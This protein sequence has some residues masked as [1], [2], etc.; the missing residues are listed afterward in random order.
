MSP[1]SLELV[2]SPLGIVIGVV[3]VLV[4]AGLSLLAW[5]RTGFA[6][7]PGILEALR[8]VLVAMVAIT[9]NQPEWLAQYVP[10]ERPTL[11]VLW[12]ASGSMQTQ[13]V[14][15]PARP[16]DTPKTRADAVQPLIHEQRWTS[17]AEKMNV[18]VEP[19]SS[20]T[21][22][23][24]EGTD[25]NAALNSVLDK[26]KNLR[27][28]VLLSDGDWNLGDP[29]VRAATRLR[30]K[31]IPVF[32]VG[33]GSE[34]RLPDVELVS[35]DAPTFGVVG[36]LMRIPF[37]IESALPRDHDAVVTLKSSTGEVI[38]HDVSIP[39]MGRVEDAVL[40]KP[41]QVGEVVLTMNVPPDPDE[42]IKENNERSVPIT[43]R[44]EA[45]K[46]L[47]VESYP[48]W[49]YRYLR[50]ALE[51]DP[52]VE[53]SCLLF[54]PGLSKVGGGKGYLKEFPGTLEELSKFDVI[55]LGDV[56]VAPGQLTSEH[57]RLIKGLVQ[58]QASGLILMPGIRGGH[59]SLLSTELNELYPV[60]L[61][62]SQPRGWGSRVPA[63]FELTESGRR[64]L[65]T[66][67]EDSEEENARTWETLPGFQWYAPVIR[68]K[69][70]TEVLATHRT[71]TSRF[72][73]VPLLATK[74][75]GTG[76]ILFMGSDGAWRWREGV[77]DKYHYRFWGQVARWMAYQRNMAQGQTMR[78]FYSPDRPQAADVVTLNANV[79]SPGG[80]PLQDGT[81][82]VQITAPSGKTESVQL[83]AGDDEWGLFSGKFTPDEHGEYKLTLS[84]RENGGTLETK[85]SVQGVKRERIGRPA[86]LDVL[87][88]IASVTRG[89]LADPGEM[90][91]ILEQIAALPEPEP[92]VRRLR[93]WCHPVWAG[94]LV[95]LLGVFWVGRKMIG[96]V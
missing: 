49:E 20:A 62:E 26:H 83:A 51:R 63:Q 50:N 70:G 54:H 60:V 76:K 66:K 30:M 91:G 34:T 81:V 35:L 45:L 88:E 29:P 1:G 57:C 13:D 96:T 69:A 82:M 90:A 17:L 18:I 86:R 78:L 28:V 6:R 87:E 19:F 7:G 84:C 92:I 3:S 42:L 53:A 93:L 61:D 22:D 24:S 8:V 95:M 64:S 14:L 23:P 75:Y 73:R 94:I 27:G 74:T 32:A 31:K 89:R 39:A 25:M 77:E 48:R 71:E 11:T 67:L 21:S 33:V 16:N 59:F 5:Y 10:D 43:I 46:V 41:E 85:L 56:G 15:D 9:L 55:F 4:T 79:M 68:A 80:E 36:K 47:L 72:G 44:E 38:T 40:W 12:D 58:S 52:G 2:W 65:L 37:T